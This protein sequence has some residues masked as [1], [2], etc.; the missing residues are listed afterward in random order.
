MIDTLVH[1]YKKEPGPFRRLSLL[2]D[3]DALHIMHQLCDDTIFGSRFKD[4]EWYLSAR[5]MTEQWTRS[6][7]IARGGSPRELAPVYMTFGRSP[8]IEGGSQPGDPPP[9]LVPLSSF[10]EGDVSFTYPDS[11]ISLWFWREKPHE[12]YHPDVHGI[13]FTRQEIISLIAQRGLPED[14]QM[15]LPSG[16]APYI[17]AQV[18][19]LEPLKQFVPPH[20]LSDW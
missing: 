7:F 20:Q 16:L 13:V 11:M 12:Y 17:E 5:R 18:W 10:D 14:W 4:P 3:E 6:S 8:W 15:G 9:I 2:P 1:Y 19:N